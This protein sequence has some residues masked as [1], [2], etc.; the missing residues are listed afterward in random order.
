M[1]IADHIL[2]HPVTQARLP[3]RA[4]EVRWPCSA[5]AV[6]AALRLE[7]SRI[8]HHERAALRIVIEPVDGHMA[9]LSVDLEHRGRIVRLLPARAV[10]CRIVAGTDT[11]SID[12]MEGARRLISLTFRD[13]SGLLYARTDLL[14]E[15][16]LGGGTYDQP[17][18]T[19]LADAIAPAA[20][21]SHDPCTNGAGLCRESQPTDHARHLSQSLGVQ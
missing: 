2:R 17:S 16:G 18:M 14:A 11:F 4:F 10:V 1:T 9:R 15:I 19:V 5:V 20:A 13:D 8:H 3:K 7:P 21:E 12:A 6:A